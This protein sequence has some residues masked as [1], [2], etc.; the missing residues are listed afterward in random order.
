[1]GRVVAAL[2]VAT[3]FMP[4]PSSPT[5]MAISMLAAY[6]AIAGAAAWIDR[7]RRPPT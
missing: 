4:P 7:A 6:F 5:E 2:A 3:P 1:V